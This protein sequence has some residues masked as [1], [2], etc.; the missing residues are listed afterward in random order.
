[1]N[2]LL[3]A[4]YVIILCWLLLRVPFIK[5]AGLNPGKLL[6]LFLFKIIAGLAIG[7]IA[8]HIYGPGN[9]YWDI[10]DYAKEE[11]Q[12]LITNPAKYFTKNQRETST[13]GMA[14]WLGYRPPNPNAMFNN[15]KRALAAAE[16]L[17]LLVK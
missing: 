13:K 1:M 16:I 9:D 5:N 17:V 10:N 15:A 11:S 12:L 2:Y 8:I 14:H 6:W 7:W 4:A 3:F